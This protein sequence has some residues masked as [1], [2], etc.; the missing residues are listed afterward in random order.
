MVAED[1]QV[2]GLRDRVVGRIRYDVVVFR[3]F[4]DRRE[5][6]VELFLRE[7]KEIEIAVERL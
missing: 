5:Q 3:D 6:S 1:D 4:L 7:S 2:A